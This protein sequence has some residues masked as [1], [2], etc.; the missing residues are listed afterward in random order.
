MRAS[1]IADSAATTVRIKNTKIWPVKSTKK[2][3]K[4]IKLKFIDRNIISIDISRI[5][6]FFLFRN[7]PAKEILNN[8]EL[9]IK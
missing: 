3:P 6:I 8:T 7:I 1:P 5:R 2:F 4:I 9:K